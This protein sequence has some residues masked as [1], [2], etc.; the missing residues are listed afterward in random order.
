MALFPILICFTMIDVCFQEVLGDCDD[1]MA[2]LTETAAKNKQYN[3]LKS[4]LATS[5]PE[6]ETRMHNCS[7]EVN[8]GSDP[9]EQLEELKSITN[10]VIAEGKLVED[11]RTVGDDLLGILEALE[12]SDTPKAHDIQETVEKVATKYDMIQEEVV[13]KQHQITKAITESQD[14]HHTLDG[15][16]GW[17]M[18]TEAVFDNMKPVSLGRSQLNDQIQA[19]RVM[20]SDIENH[21]ARIEG[22]VEQCRG[23]PGAEDK[24]EQLTDR[25]DILDSRAEQRGAELEEVNQKIGV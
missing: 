25:F 24:C 22:V 11:L 10:D 17:I 1:M 12:C 16:L 13:D 8:P 7:A 23:K 19:H 4:R 5:L 18:E 3:D 15:L 21:K 9:K 6:M 14:V 2:K 20:Q